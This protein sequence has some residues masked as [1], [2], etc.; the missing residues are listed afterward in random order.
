MAKEFVIPSIFTAIDKT[1]MV[2]DKIER[3]FMQFAGATTGAVNRA[4]R[5]FNKIGD[6]ADSAFGKIVNFKNAV[7]ASL[8]GV[9]VKKGFDMAASVASIADE[10]ATTTK[11]LGI[12]TDA[13]QE[14]TYAA[15]LQNIEQET[16][17]KSIEKLNKNVGD[18]QKGQ[19][20]LFAAL[21]KTNPHLLQQLRHT[22]DTGAAFD[23][24]MAAIAKQPTAMAKASMAQ[25]MFGKSGQAM[26]NLLADGPEGFARLREEAKKYG[27]ILSEDAIEAASKFDDAH[28]R[29]NYVLAGV[30]NTIGAEL[31]PILTAYMMRLVDWYSNNKQLVQQKVGE[32]IDKISKA[33]QWGVENF[34]T[35]IKYLKIFIGLLIFLKA[36]STVMAILNAGIAIYNGFVAVATGLQWLWNVA[37]AANPMTIIIMAII[38]GIAALIAII[39]LVVKH[40]KGW[41]EQWDSIMKFMKAV[42]KLWALGVKLEWLV[43]QNAFLTM[44]DA[45]VMAWKWAQNKLGALSDEQ[46]KKDIAAIKE[47]QRVR[48]AAIKQTAADMKAT[49]LDAK[50]AL[51]WKLS[52]DKGPTM[53]DKWDNAHTPYPARV[54]P[55]TNP[56]TAQ[57]DA[58]AAQVMS[59]PAGLVTVDFKNMPQGTEVKKKEG[60]KVK[61][62]TS[63]TLGFGK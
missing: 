9:A 48:V 40:V 38:I 33:V 55:A 24:A 47:Q 16:L 21:K 3:K 44:V 7:A 39:M 2:V 62:K 54:D 31:F 10:L 27:L 12:A 43:L 19:G 15:K 56:K 25:I 59:N 37:M 22:K 14:L 52:W 11:R 26:L 29:M 28:D 36:V 4:G 1:S 60:S 57:N 61:I 23:I 50:D 20:A 41:G 5:V 58:L 8:I 63:S 49:A 42:L 53:Q 34:D 17:D 51:Q 30:K 45:I 46:Y 32:W 6:W 35:I 18:A 13:Y